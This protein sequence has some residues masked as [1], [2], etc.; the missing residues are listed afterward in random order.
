MRFWHPYWRVFQTRA[1]ER[2]STEAFSRTLSVVHSSLSRL[3]YDTLSNTATRILN[4]PSRVVPTAVE[5][6][7]L[8]RTRGARVARRLDSAKDEFLMIACDGLWTRFKPVDARRQFWCCESGLSRLVSGQR[9][10]D[11][12]SSGK[13]QDT[14][15][16]ALELSKVS[17]IGSL[18]TY[19]RYFVRNETHVA[20]VG[21]G[22]VDAAQFV[23]T[24]LHARCSYLG[25]NK[26]EWPD[27]ATVTKALVDDCVTKKNCGDNVSV[28]ILR[29]TEKDSPAQ[30]R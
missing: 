13:P 3:V 22:Q 8:K 24:R 5:Y 23:R 16:S 6:E 9:G 28:I 2:L 4:L 18:E 30:P 25:G 12:A 19:R 14:R 29:F 7:S 15:S 1:Q 10:Y 27:L 17:F 20:R 11:R 21:G 26:Q